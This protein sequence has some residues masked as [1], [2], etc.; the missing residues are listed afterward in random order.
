MPLVALSVGALGS[1]HCVGMCGPLVVASAKDL[2]SQTNYQ[3]GRLLSYLI[4]GAGSGLLGQ[5]FLWQQE[6]PI[7]TIIPSILMALALIFWGTNFVRHKSLTPS[8]FAKI[9]RK[10]PLRGPFL[11]GIFSAF[12]PCGFL[13]GVALTVATFQSPLLGAVAMGSFWLGTLPALSGA[14]WLVSRLAHFHT[15]MREQALGLTLISFG[16][17]SLSYRFYQFYTTGSCH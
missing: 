17:I 3:M 15:R 13:Y 9:Y 10:L 14:S 16:L 5:W 11:I 7:L 4:L 1:L 12:L 6:T 8:L 2:K